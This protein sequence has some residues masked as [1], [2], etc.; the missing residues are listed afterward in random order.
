MH[1]FRVCGQAR[2][3]AVLLK[4]VH[5]LDFV[6]L[7][8]YCFF[9]ARASDSGFSAVKGAIKI[10]YGSFLRSRTRLRVSNESQNFKPLQI[11]TDT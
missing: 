2:V 1:I 11:L 7:F 9:V 4:V 8:D 6:L 3:L 5:T 10:Y